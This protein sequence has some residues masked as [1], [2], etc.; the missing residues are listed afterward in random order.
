MTPDIHRHIG[1]LFKNDIVQFIAFFNDEIGFTHTG[2][3]HDEIWYEDGE[4]ETEIVYKRMKVEYDSPVIQVVDIITKQ[5]R[6]DKEKQHQV[7]FLEWMHSVRMYDIIT[8][9]KQ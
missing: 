5:D 6:K 4:V 8:S 3:T 7:E 2:F 9:L 1:K